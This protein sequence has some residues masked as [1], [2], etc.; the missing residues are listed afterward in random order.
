MV[1]LAPAYTSSDI[2]PAS[3][4]EKPYCRAAIPKAI[5]RGKKPSNRDTESR[6]P[7]SRAGVMLSSSRRQ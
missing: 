7:R 1:G 4:A 2:R 3:R 6:I 5:P